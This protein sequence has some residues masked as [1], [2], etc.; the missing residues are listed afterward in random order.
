MHPA[1]A[2][3]YEVA[4]YDDEQVA[5]ARQH[6]A[7]RKITGKGSPPV[8][9]TPVRLPRW[10][11]G[12]VVLAVATAFAVA[13]GLCFLAYA[14]RAQGGSVGTVGELVTWP[15]WWLEL[16][17]YAW[18]GALAANWMAGRRH[19]ERRRQLQAHLRGEK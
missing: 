13:V 12:D 19:R 3:W 11:P 18:A 1:M 16:A 8:R 14:A 10:T 7:M 6:T 5:A 4:G 2:R 17:L 15:P 9:D